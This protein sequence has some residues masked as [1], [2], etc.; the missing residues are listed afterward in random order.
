LFA[1]T[2]PEDIVANIWDQFFQKGIIAIFIYALAIFEVLKKKIV[3][4]KD[5]TNIF[6]MLKSSLPEFVNDWKV[7]NRASKKLKLKIEEISCK[8]IY[9]RPKVIEEYEEQHRCKR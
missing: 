2:L 9:I 8:R 5:S 1:N 6:L 4:D 7:L 3:G